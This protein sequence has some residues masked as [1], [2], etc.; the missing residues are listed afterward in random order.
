MSRFTAACIQLNSQDDIA[1][2]CAHVETFV[3]Q[4]A[5]KG[6]QLVMLPENAFFM[7]DASKGGYAPI[8]EAEHTGFALCRKLAAELKIWLLVGSLA[9]KPDRVCEKNMCVNR[10]V[11]I[12]DKGEIVTRYDKIHLF[13]VVLPSGET[14]SE[15]ARFIPGDKAMTADLPWGTLG[16]SICYDVRFPHVYRLLA[17]EGATLLAVPAAFTHT[18]GKAHWHVLLRARA[19]ENGAFV[20]APAQCGTHPGSR[21]TY[22]HSLIISPWGE[23]LAEADETTPGII[24]AEIDTAKADEARRIIPSLQHDRL[25]GL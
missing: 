22:G 8:L 4:A 15:S 3:R 21:R 13:D 2:N 6:A 23:I 7:I 20:F 24:M 5:E 18:T 12:D 19:I 10:S 1:A 25:F 9:L 17:K 11:L 14:Y 16:L